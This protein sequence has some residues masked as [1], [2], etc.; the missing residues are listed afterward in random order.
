RHPAFTP[1][2]YTTPSRSPC[3]E[4]ERLAH[5][6]QLRRRHRDLEHEPARAQLS[7]ALRP[8]P[9]P[10]EAADLRVHLIDEIL[11]ARQIRLGGLEPAD[12]K[13]TRLNSSHVKIS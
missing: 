7:V 6:P 8:A 9:L 5:V 4:L 10:G 13:S 11:E 12:R 3:S 2:P 1:V